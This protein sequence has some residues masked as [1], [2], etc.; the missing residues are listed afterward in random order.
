MKELNI[1]AVVGVRSVGPRVA[2][3]FVAHV[4]LI[5]HVC[6]HIHTPTHTD[7]Y[8]FDLVSG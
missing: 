8:V 2:Q 3:V 6:T 4:V 1:E 7:T 5:L